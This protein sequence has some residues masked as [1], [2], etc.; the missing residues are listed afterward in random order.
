MTRHRNSPLPRAVRGVSLVELMIAMVIGL[1]VSG[2]AIALFATHRMTYNASESLGRI[3]ESIRTA[4]EIMSKDVREAGA[5]PCD[6]S[7][8]NGSMV[9]GLNASTAWWRNWNN[10]ISAYNGSTAMTGTAFGTTLRARV[11][12]TDALEMKS[13]EGTTSV[14]AAD[15][16]DAQVGNAIT[17]NTTADLAVGD[18]LVVCDY[19]DATIFQAT[20]LTGTT[21]S[22]AASGTPGNASANL[23]LGPNGNDKNGNPVPALATQGTIGRM[24]ASQ[25]YI[26]CNLR[27]ACDQPG[28]RSLYRVTMN[29]TAGVA[30]AATPDEIAAGVSNMA[31]TYLQNGGTAWVAN[32]GV[33]NWQAV[34]GVR[35]VLT[36]TGT[37]RAGTN[38]APITRTVEQVLTVRNH[39]P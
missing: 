3:Q 34:N 36:F 24:V 2:A 32:T 4:Y 15:L 9:N 37:E 7:L 29:N 21:I 6:S 20:G 38:N 1:I 11:A 8:A 39:L 30:A 19:R 26:G 22:H 33:T 13:F 35:V 12:G 25:W 18:I 14:V 16:T 5:V 28:G 17:V 23:Q 27:V 10:G 31:I